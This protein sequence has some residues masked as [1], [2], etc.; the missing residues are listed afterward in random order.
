MSRIFVR[1]H[2]FNV[3]KSC[4]IS[5]CFLIHQISTIYYY[6]TFTLKFEE[7]FIYNLFILIKID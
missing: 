6:C 4:I 5:K 1:Y 2:V 3:G 7:I